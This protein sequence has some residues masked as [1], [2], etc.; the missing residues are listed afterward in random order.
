ME[1]RTTSVAA[2]QACLEEMERA[3]SMA[4]QHAVSLAG[5]LADA[6]EEIKAL[7]AEIAAMKAKSDAGTPGEGG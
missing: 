5:A 3:R 4:Q 7:K 1:A 2:A 6:H